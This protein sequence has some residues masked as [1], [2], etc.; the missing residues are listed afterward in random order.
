M[1]PLAKNEESYCKDC[2][3]RGPNAYGGQTSIGSIKK[4]K[5]SRPIFEMSTNDILVFKKTRGYQMK[6]Y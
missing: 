2:D 3:P 4:N 6:F 1:F 5:R